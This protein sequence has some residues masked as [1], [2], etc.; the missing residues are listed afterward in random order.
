M[1]RHLRWLAILGIPAAAAAVD[2]DNV[3]AGRPLR[4]EDAQ[5]VA[6]HEWAI[7]IGPAFASQSRGR[8]GL[9]LAAEAVHG[10]A[11][12]T[13]M[14][15][16]VVA[17]AGDR[18]GSRETGL[19]VE[20]LEIGVLHA[21]NRELRR[22]PALALRAGAEFSP[23]GDRDGALL[24]VRTVASRGL[25]HYDRLH[26]NLDADFAIGTPSGERTFRPG[27]M[28]GYS[29]PLGFPRRFDSTGVAEFGVRASE[30][31][32]AGAVASLG[33][34]L[35]QQVSVRTVLD[36]G[37]RSELASRGAPHEALAVVAGCSVGF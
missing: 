3:D 15:L 12:D 37:I 33:A 9:A 19:G 10:F 35:R 36:L 26:L 8:A 24:R 6:L 20:T 32:G 4:F 28:L 16:G 23:G 31:E 17:A 13:Q 25:V 27:A 22:L 5:P 14:S 7:E 2:H 30:V 11:M 18:A 34:G 29:R 1:R 21:F